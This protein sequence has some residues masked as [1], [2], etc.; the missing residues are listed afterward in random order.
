[1]EKTINVEI[2]NPIF[3]RISLQIPAIIS[4]E[5]LKILC[6]QRL[7]NSCHLFI[8]FINLFDG[9]VRKIVWTKFFY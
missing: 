5:W 7:Y 6:A 4:R 8:L 9:I 2:H 3:Y 1:M